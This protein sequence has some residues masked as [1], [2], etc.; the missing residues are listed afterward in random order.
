[1]QTT[2]Q[3]IAAIEDVDL[4]VSIGDDQIADSVSRINDNYIR[5]TGKPLFSM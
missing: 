4:N 2:R 3:I 5:R 1:V